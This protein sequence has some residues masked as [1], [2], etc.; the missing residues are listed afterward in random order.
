MGRVPYTKH[1]SLGSMVDCVAYLGQ[2]RCLRPQG[3]RLT[4]FKHRLA[5][6]GGRL[7]PLVVRDE[8]IDRKVNP[9]AEEG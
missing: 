4:P 9:S 8:V 3:R 2:A 6:I 1:S 5:E 7:E